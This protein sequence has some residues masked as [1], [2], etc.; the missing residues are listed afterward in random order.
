MLSTAS[1]FCH[2]AAVTTHNY[3]W[4]R[5]SNY[6]SYTRHTKIPLCARF[7]P[8]FI[9][10][11]CK[12]WVTYFDRIRGGA[13]CIMHLKYATPSTDVTNLTS[14][15]YNL[16]SHAVP[17]LV[18]NTAVHLPARIT[19]HVHDRN[20]SHS[21]AHFILLYAQDVLM[22]HRLN[23][24]VIPNWWSA[25]RVWPV[26]SVLLTGETFQNRPRIRLKDQSIYRKIKFI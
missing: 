1:M 2:T 23:R 16:M 25:C 11:C 5:I 4:H 18:C 19:V 12:I 20:V 10:M 3:R 24:T 14:S 21:P 6:I 8:F 13:Y 22:L 26:C 15:D 9:K 7:I 17:L